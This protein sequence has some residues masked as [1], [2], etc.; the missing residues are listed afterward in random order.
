MA[1]SR[2]LEPAGERIARLKPNGKPILSFFRS[3]APSAKSRYFK[4]EYLINQGGVLN[5]PSQGEIF[6][7]CVIDRGADNFDWAL[8]DTKRLSSRAADFR[9]NFLNAPSVAAHSGQII[10]DRASVQAGFLKYIENIIKNKVFVAT[11]DVII[12]SMAASSKRASMLFQPHVIP[13]GAWSSL[14]TG[15]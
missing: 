12:N 7:Y 11:V 10:K 5:A 8:E 2:V 15:G 6:R 14:V 9:V 13:E 3:F 4:V 1:R